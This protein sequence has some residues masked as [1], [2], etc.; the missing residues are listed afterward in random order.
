LPFLRFDI[1]ILVFQENH[2]K[3]HSVPVDM[4]SW[5][6]FI[7]LVSLYK[8][9][10]SVYNYAMISSYYSHISN[11]ESPNNAQFFLHSTGRHVY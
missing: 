1:L 6:A 3:M 10:Y 5:N 2:K 9:F 4:F 8:T 7:P 11:L